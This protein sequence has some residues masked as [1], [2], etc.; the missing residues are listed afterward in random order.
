VHVKPLR[1]PRAPGNPRSDLRTQCQSQ[2]GLFP[3]SDHRP[4]LASLKL[5]RPR[6]RL[7]ARRRGRSSLTPGPRDGK[8]RSDE[9]KPQQQSHPNPAVGDRVTGSIQHG[10]LTARVPM[11][12]DMLLAVL[13]RSWLPPGSYRS[14]RWGVQVPKR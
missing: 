3:A 7:T 11:G 10:P 13:R 14:G 6:P 9:E 8:N 2:G 5:V 1:R 4:P 12:A